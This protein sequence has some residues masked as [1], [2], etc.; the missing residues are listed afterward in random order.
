MSPPVLK[1]VLL[2][3]AQAGNSRVQGASVVREGWG[4]FLEKSDSSK[5]LWR[6]LSFHMAFLQTGL[7][8]APTHSH[9]Y[10]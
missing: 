10:P 1:S 8:E 5:T 3:G 9:L 2:R 4:D 7:L 6:G